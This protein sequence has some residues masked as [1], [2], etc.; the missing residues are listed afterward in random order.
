[1]RTNI[2]NQ[3]CLARL[4]AAAAVV[5]ALLLPGCNAADGPQRKPLLP[6]TKNARDES[7]R[8]QA[9]SDSFPTAQQAGLRGAATE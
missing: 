8:K 7:I 4:T 1:L 2:G 6:F 3:R 5:A 9:H